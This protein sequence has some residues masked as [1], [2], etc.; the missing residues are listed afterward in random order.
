MGDLPAENLPIWVR[1]WAMGH[2]PD[3]AHDRAV[4]T[5]REA[6]FP[7]HGLDPWFD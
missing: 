5:T 6:V 1:P 4:M 7:H 3:N 2:N